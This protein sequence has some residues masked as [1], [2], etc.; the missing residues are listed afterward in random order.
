MNTY[1]DSLDMLHNLVLA[2]VGSLIYMVVTTA[3]IKGNQGLT[4]D[5]HHEAVLGFW[6]LLIFV[7]FSILELSCKRH[8]FGTKKD[9][10]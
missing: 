10:K 2:L 4:L 7:I 8:P 5:L 6:C 1:K 9:V 3:Y